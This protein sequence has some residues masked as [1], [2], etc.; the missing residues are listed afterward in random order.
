M[1]HNKILIT[2]GAGFVGSNIAIK[3]KESRKKIS[4]IVLDNLKRRG[5]ELNLSRLEKHGIKFIH[6]DIR[7]KEDLD[8]IGPIDCLIECSAESSVLSGY[9][10]AAGYVINTNLLG[11]INCLDIVKKYNSDMIFLSSSRVYPIEAINSIK[12]NETESHFRICKRQSLPG[13]SEKGISESFPLIGVRSLYGTT[14]LCSEHIIQ[15][16]IDMYDIRCVINRCGILTGPWQMGK[17]DQGVIALWVAKHLFDGELNYIG[18]G[19]EG[20]QVRDI[21]HINDLISLLTSQMEKIS[22]INGQVYNVGGGLKNSISLSELTELCEEHTGN[23]I[24]IG[25]IKDNRPGDIK[26]Y[27]TDNSLVTSTLGWQP[28]IGCNQIIKEMV[29]WINHNKKLL[30]S[31]FV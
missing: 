4:I 29:T 24:N 13:V 14:K 28:I 27:I 12:C 26:A 22:E 30:K 18:F 31:V 5:S 11:T 10:G 1:F 21:L 7:N 8:S 3:L 25:K 2:G 6:G 15:E 9:H 23:T 16:Y 17:I 20:K 19:G